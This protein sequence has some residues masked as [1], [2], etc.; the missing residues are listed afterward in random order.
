M[1]LRA[2]AVLLSTRRPAQG[3][4]V[5]VLVAVPGAPRRGPARAA[6]RALAALGVPPVV[7]SL[8]G[9][10]LRVFPRPPP[11]PPHGGAGGEGAGPG[12]GGR[13]FFARW[14]V[15][16]WRPHA[17]TLEAAEVGRDKN[18]QACR[19]S[20]AHV[21]MQHPTPSVGSRLSERGLPRRC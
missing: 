17:A 13:A 10:P 20:V 12:E 7:V 6:R 5:V 21:I 19:S 8:A 18:V 4:T 3:E 1:G 11:A 14:K 2:P 16:I 15:R 9:R